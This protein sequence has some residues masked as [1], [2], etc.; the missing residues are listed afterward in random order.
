MS[1]QSEPLALAGLAVALT[2]LAPAAAQDDWG[3]LPPG[4]ARE[5]VYYT[6]N[7]CHSLAIVRQ[8][9]LPRER[10]D[11]LMDWMVE[12]QGMAPMEPEV[13]ARVVDYLAE[14]YGYAAD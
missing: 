10:W 7:A 12:E 2:L 11:Y 1:R 3:G 5:D 4:E 13:R 14:H 6:C 8:Q 9:N